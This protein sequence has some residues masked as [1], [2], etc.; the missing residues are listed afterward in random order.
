MNHSPLAEAHARLHD[1]ARERALELRR[2]AID[3]FW[4]GAAAALVDP[5]AQALRSSARLVARWRRHRLLRE[6]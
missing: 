4:N 5:A 1:A 3:D 6:A 2:Q